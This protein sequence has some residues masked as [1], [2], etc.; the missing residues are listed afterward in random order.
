LR[1]DIEA[2]GGSEGNEKKKKKKAGR[3]KDETVG[4]VIVGC[5]V[6]CSE[7]NDQQN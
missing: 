4:I 1:G 7:A 6:I 3:E 2:I 5:S